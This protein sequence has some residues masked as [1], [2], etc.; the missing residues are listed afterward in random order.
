M[1]GPSNNNTTATA[2]LY[3][4]HSWELNST[5]HTIAFGRKLP[6]Y[7]CHLLGF[8]YSGTRLNFNRHCIPGMRR[9]TE[10]RQNSPYAFPVVFEEALN[11]P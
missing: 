7:H 6:H 2:W 9:K 1:S 11:N 4:L 5:W 3:N 8:S 10:T